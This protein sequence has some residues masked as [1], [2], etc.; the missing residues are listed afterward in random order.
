MDVGLLYAP[1]GLTPLQAIQ[2][3]TLVPAKVMGRLSQSGKIEVGKQADMILVDG[4]PLK[5]IRT[6]KKSN[7]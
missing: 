4:D 5:R 6:F 3:A 2:T 7:G 1:S